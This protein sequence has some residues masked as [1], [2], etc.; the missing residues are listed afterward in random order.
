VRVRV[1]RASV[2]RWQRCGAAVR[3]GVRVTASS[4]NRTRRDETRRDGRV[5]TSLRIFQTS[6]AFS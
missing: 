6:T 5:R 2:V 4:M 1:H 3:A